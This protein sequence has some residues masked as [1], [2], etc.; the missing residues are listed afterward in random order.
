MID[1]LPPL[2]EVGFLLQCLR[3]FC[4][5]PFGVVDGGRSH[6]IDANGAVSVAAA[7]GNEGG[8]HLPSSLGTKQRWFVDSALLALRYKLMLSEKS[9]GAMGRMPG[10]GSGGGDSEPP[11]PSMASPLG[12]MMRLTDLGQEDDE[13]NTRITMEKFSAEALNELT[14]RDPLRAPPSRGVISLSA[15]SFAP[16]VNKTPLNST[17]DVSEQQPARGRF[18]RGA[19]PRT[20]G[21]QSIPLPA[22]TD[23]TDATPP[24]T[25]PLVDRWWSYMM[26]AQVGKVNRLL[27]ECGVCREGCTSSHAKMWEDACEAQVRKAARSTTTIKASFDRVSARVPSHKKETPVVDDT[28]LLHRAVELVVHS[29]AVRK[30]AQRLE[31]ASAMPHDGPLASAT[32]VSLRGIAGLGIEMDAPSP[33]PPSPRSKRQPK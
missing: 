9:G 30:G 2:D 32:A 6:G 5:T 22:S 13:E 26:L 1:A 28:A 4:S 31:G 10:L 16:P 12:A 33:H 20:V 19:A 24:L 23:A 29:E 3:D 21:V 14:S 25:A 27:A 7:I 11:T 8:P 17:G 18:G 15:P